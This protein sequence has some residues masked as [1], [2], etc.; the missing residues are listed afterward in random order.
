M[1]T[2]NLDFT[3]IIQ[4]SLIRSKQKKYV[5]GAV[6]KEKEKVERYEYFV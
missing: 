3:K 6:I 4:L 5:F 1:K 2:R